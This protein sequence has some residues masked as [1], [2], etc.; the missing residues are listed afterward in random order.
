M[1]F[2]CIYVCIY[3]HTYVNVYI[4]VCMYI[5]NAQ[6]SLLICPGYH[7][8]MYTC[9]FTLI[10][11]CLCVNIYVYMYIHIYIHHYKLVKRV[12]Y[13]NAMLPQ[14]TSIKAL[15]PWLL[16]CD[17]APA[18]SSPAV[19]PH[20]DAHTTPNSAAMTDL[21]GT[22]MKPKYHERRQD[23]QSNYHAPM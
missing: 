1:I 13:I 21:F 17:A 2:V 8:R 11:I 14:V 22:K 12:R 6:K 23:F 5:R 3:L 4:Q 9:T 7:I 15:S 10:Y 16:S 19:L 18:E 20:I